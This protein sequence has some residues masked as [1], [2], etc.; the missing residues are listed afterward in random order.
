MTD[1]VTLISKDFNTAI[2][3]IRTALDLATEPVQ[4]TPM[5]QISD[6][7]K[8]IAFAGYIDRAQPHSTFFAN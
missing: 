6:N 4:D 5:C 2:N 3:C 1:G 8:L 7:V